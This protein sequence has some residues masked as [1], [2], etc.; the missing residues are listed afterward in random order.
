MKR[1]ELL[2]IVWEMKP[3]NLNLYYPHG[4]SDGFWKQA[5]TSEVFMEDIDEIR[6]EAQRLEKEPMPELTYT[7][8]SIYARTGSR[9]EY[10]RVYF[11]RRRRLNTYVMLSL[12]EPGNVIFL[13][14]LE[15]ILW[16]EIGRASCRERVF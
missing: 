1:E 7:L 6:T 3:A 9:L 4:D 11:E 15:N 16:S 5:S 10:E 14:N 2:S 8:F 12:L 13:E